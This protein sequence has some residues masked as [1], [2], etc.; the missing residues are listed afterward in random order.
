MCCAGLV[1]YVLLF[2]CV[3][4]VRNT[5][6]R[7]QLAEVALQ[8]KA[9]PGPS[10]ADAPTAA[11]NAPSPSTPAP[12]DHRQKGVVE[13]TAFEDEETCSGIVFKRKRKADAAVPANLASGDRAPSFR[14]NP[15][16]AYSPCDIVVHEGG[17]ESTHG[18]DHGAPCRRSTSQ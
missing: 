14:E 3:G 2:S 10:D 18:G 7:R 11:A 15:P 5:E 6:N 17:G 9:A 12:V 8:R 13:A 1:S 16:S 4:M